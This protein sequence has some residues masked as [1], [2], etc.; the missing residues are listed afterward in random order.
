MA[1]I[2]Q[3]PRAEVEQGGTSA[4]VVLGYVLAVFVPFVG[5]VL[6]IIAATRPARAVSKHGVWIILVSVVM[7]FLL[8]YLLTGSSSNG[9][10][11]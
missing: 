2:H 9:S 1:P 3:S 11:A 8:L 10:S 4:L 5:F 6:G 7:F